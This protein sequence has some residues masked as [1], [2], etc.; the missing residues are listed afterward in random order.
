MQTGAPLS[1]GIITAFLEGDGELLNS[2]DTSPPGYFFCLLSILAPLVAWGKSLKF[3]GARSS[4]GVKRHKCMRASATP[5]YNG[6]GPG[7]HPNST[8]GILALTYLTR[9]L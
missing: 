7:P 2:Y 1:K 3:S 5:S 8:I 4:S 9:M 6:R